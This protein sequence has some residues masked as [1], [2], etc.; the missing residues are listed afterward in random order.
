[1]GDIFRICYLF[2]TFRCSKFPGKK[3]DPEIS[4][5]KTLVSAVNCITREK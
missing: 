1:M 3:P 2:N 5:L 4:V